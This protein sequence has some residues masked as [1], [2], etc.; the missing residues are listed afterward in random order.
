MSAESPPL[1]VWILPILTVLIIVGAFFTYTYSSFGP[2]ERV[3]DQSFSS[4]EKALDENARDT[5]A[6]SLVILGSSLTEQALV[7]PL[8]L[9]DSVSGMTHRKAKV[10]RVAINYLT[11]DLAERMKFFELISKH[12]SDYLFLENFTVNLDGDSSLIPVQIDAALLDIRNH[13]R[14]VIG[15]STQDNYYAKWYT[16]DSK[17]LPGSTYYTNDFDSAT[18]KSLQGKINVV[19]NA[20][21]NGA[22]NIAYKH[23]NAQHKKVVFLDM[24]QSIRLRKNFLSDAS[25]VKLDEVLQYYHSKFGI[26]YWRYPGV[27]ADSCF[28][29]GA[30]VNSKGAMEYQKWFVSEIASRN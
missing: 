16:F 17:P 11:M 24:P 20:S 9:Q 12:P 21:R 23:L 7:D 4:L 25:A 14:K 10:L 29:D 3:L 6:V 18:F 1:K 26:E 8:A 19:R 30:H 2:Y 13:V 27:M 22:A 15:M 5:S 28:Y